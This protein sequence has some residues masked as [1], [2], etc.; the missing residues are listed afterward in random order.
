M[1]ILTDEGYIQSFDIDQFEYDNAVWVAR[2]FNNPLKVF[3]KLAENYITERN[4]D[5]F[6]REVA[7]IR[8]ESK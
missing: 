4:V 5:Y 7:K 8:N 2:R 3:V 1:V 6:W